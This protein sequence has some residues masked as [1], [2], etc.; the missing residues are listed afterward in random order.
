[1]PLT[2]FH[3]NG[4]L[5]LPYSPDTVGVLGATRTLLTGWIDTSSFPSW[6]RGE[7]SALEGL[8]RLLDSDGAS[9]VRR[10]RGDF[11][12]AHLAADRARLRLY[13]GVASTIPLFWRSGDGSFAWAT[14]PGELLDGEGRRLDDVDLD[15]LPMIIAEAG[16]PHDRSW[17]K[18][19]W[20]LPSGECLTL[21]AGEVRPRVDQ[22][23][24]FSPAEDVPADPRSAAEEL[25][26]R[27]SQAC[28]RMLEPEDAAV[29]MLSGGL[30]S[31]AVTHEA[32]GRCKKAVGLHFTLESFPG[33]AEDSEVAA[34]IAGACDAAF[35]PYDMSKHV[36]E[37][38]DY[39][40]GPEDGSLP[41]TH[42]PLPGYPAAATQAES[43][44]ARFVLS[45]LMSDQVLMHDWHRGIFEVLG[46]AVLNP[47]R[48]GEPIWQTLAQM[49]GS[50]FAGSGRRRRPLGL[51]RSLLGGDPTVALPDPGLMV[52]HVGLTPDA[53]DRITD[54]L[55]GSTYRVQAGARAMGDRRGNGGRHLPHG[56]TALL[57]I[58]EALNLPH[59][60]AGWLNYFRPRGRF[61]ATPYADRDVVEFALA[62]PT[63][64]RL[65]LGYGS[66]VDKFALRLAYADGRLP[67]EV[68]T[69]MHQA[70]IDAIPAAFVNQN[71]ETCRR[72]LGEDSVLRRLGIVADD[73]A[74]N[75]S[76]GVAHRNGEPIARLCVIEQWLRR[77]SE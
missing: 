11:V 6:H 2:S 49:S 12:I 45:G 44:G 47:L 68:A 33:F 21:D 13:R 69:R 10:L 64:H 31:A 62:L 23:D 25:R 67:R 16:F 32:A 66:T 30:D 42:V 15:L 38:G 28:S 34:R 56:I 18:D 3:I 36:V 9:A 76:R 27:L 57:F 4:R 58:K 52:H 61:F 77:I 26:R 35:V 73:F 46:P 19:V 39:L 71:F 5:P 48:T 29:V 59:L 24:E 70:R 51:A 43:I 17:F 54:S 50:S 41:R 22:F 74:A 53:A 7:G 40:Q 72:L 8:Q 14:D 65:A 55:R 20:R 37:G 75:L 1:M 60:H 63:R